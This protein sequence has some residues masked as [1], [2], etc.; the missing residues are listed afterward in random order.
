MVDKPF[1]SNMPGTGSIYVPYYLH[2]I[3][4]YYLNFNSNI[5]LYGENIRDIFKVN[6]LFNNIYFVKK[7]LYNIFWKLS[8]AWQPVAHVPIPVCT[9]HF[10]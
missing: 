4:K 8:G 3:Q 2:M 7:K 6:T 1:F 5:N 9:V 10:E